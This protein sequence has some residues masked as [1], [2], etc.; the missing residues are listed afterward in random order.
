MGPEDLQRRVLLG[1][2]ASREEAES[3]RLQL[4]AAFSTARV[5]PSAQERL[6]I[7]IPTAAPVAVPPDSQ[8]AAG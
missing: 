8:A 4:G 1:R 2:Y 7:I 5:I 3:V 6:R